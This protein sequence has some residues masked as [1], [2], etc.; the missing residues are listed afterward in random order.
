MIRSK[1][2]IF[3]VVFLL[4]GVVAYLVLDGKGRSQPE[5]EEQ[6]RSSKNAVWLDLLRRP[7]LHV[8]LPKLLLASSLG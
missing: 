7:E 2:F 6:A 5:S 3:A 1:T 8:V 4:L